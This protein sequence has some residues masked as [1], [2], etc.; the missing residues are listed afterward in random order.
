MNL[1]SIFRSSSSRPTAQ[2]S[3]RST[4]SQAPAAAPQAM[5][6]EL[7][8]LK[9]EREFHNHGLSHRNRWEPDSS[10]EARRERVAAIDERIAT[11]EAQ[12]SPKGWLAR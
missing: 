4:A 6:A 12:L 3:S 10:V 9:A 11:L 8:Q 7:A 1:L 2:A 5:K